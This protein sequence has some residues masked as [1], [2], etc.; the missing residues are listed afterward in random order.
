MAAFGLAGATK[1]NALACAPAARAQAL[2]APAATQGAARRE[3]QLAFAALPSCVLF[4]HQGRT[5]LAT[6]NPLYPFAVELVWRGS[7]RWKRRVA[8]EVAERDGTGLPTAARLIHGH[9]T[10]RRRVL[11]L[12]SCRYIGG[13]PSRIRTRWRGASRTRTDWLGCFYWHV[14]SD[15]WQPY[16]SLRSPGPRSTR[17]RYRR[18]PI[19]FSTSIR[20]TRAAISERR[21]SRAPYS[22]RSFG[23]QPTSRSSRGLRSPRLSSG[24]RWDCR[25]SNCPQPSRSGSYCWD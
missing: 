1:L 16:F 8:V 22:R 9:R 12:R 21:C 14:A 17:S 3:R 23:S 19:T 5:W 25:R 18:S 2:M 13:H 20:R 11:A 7:V 24:Y 4:I 6:G 15:V 10:R